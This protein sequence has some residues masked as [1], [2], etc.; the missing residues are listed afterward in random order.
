MALRRL[1][2]E[3]VFT[4]GILCSALS[5]LFERYTNLQYL[6]F[7]ISDFIGGMF[8]GLSMVLLLFFLLNVRHKRRKNNEEGVE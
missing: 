6:D 5:V 8:T 3:H 7:S 4:L 2:N 1:K